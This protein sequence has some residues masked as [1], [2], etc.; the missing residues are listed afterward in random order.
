[1]PEQHSD[2]HLRKAITSLI[3]H[4]LDQGKKRYGVAETILTTDVDQ[5]VLR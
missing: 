4:I 1:M 2:D 5:F 3:D